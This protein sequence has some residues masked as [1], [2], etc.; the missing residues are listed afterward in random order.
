LESFLQNE[1][2]NV[3]GNT[4]IDQLLKDARFGDIISCM[5][6][7]ERQAPLTGE[8][9]ATWLISFVPLND[10]D[11][12]T[13]DSFSKIAEACNENLLGLTPMSSDKAILKA[14]SKCI[15]TVER[16][17]NI[18]QGKHVLAHILAAGVAVRCRRPIPIFTESMQAEYIA[19]LES[20]EALNKFLRSVIR[21]CVYGPSGELY[22]VIE[23]DGLNSTYLDPNGEKLIVQW[24]DL[25][26]DEWT[27][28]LNLK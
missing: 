9:L 7:F 23:H 28:F 18:T 2:S 27:T 22:Q 5:Q 1:A 17:S 15:W 16:E 25:Y 26:E 4:K 21:D 20:K 6:Q 12:Q 10:L 14:M 19:A 11:E 24:H 8:N 13:R 3:V